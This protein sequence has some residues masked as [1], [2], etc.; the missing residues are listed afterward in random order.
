MATY[1]GAL[2]QDTGFIAEAP[3][4]IRSNF[5]A[6]KDNM[7]VDAGKL[8]GRVAGNAS[9]DIPI[10]NG[11]VCTNLNADMIDGYHA[12]SFAPIGHVNSATG[13][14]NAT[15]TA[16]GFMS[17]AQYL[18][19]E[20]I[21]AG[22]QVNQN[23]FSNIVVGTTT[24][25]ADSETDTLN[26]VG[27][28][29][30]T[31]TPDEIADKVIFSIATGAITT[32]HIADGTILTSD[33]ADGQITTAKLAASAVTTAKIAAGNITTALI[34]DGNV[35]TAKI[36]DS[37]VTTAKLADGSV[38][39]AKLAS[40]AAAANLGYTPLNAAGGTISGNLTV[41]GVTTLSST[42]GVSGTLTASGAVSVGTTL[43]VTG[44]TTLK[45]TLGV[46][47]ATTLS[48]TLDVSGA[49]TF[50]GTISAGTV[51]MRDSGVI[52]GL[53]TSVG[54]YFN[55][56]VSGMYDWARSKDVW[57]YTHN[58]STL[59]FMQ[60]AS[61]NST[62]SV[63]GALTAS[64]GITGSLTGNASTAT[65]L[66][67][68]RTISL[69]GDVTGS[70]SFDGSANANIIT[71][72]ANSGVTAGTYR[73]VTVDSKGRVIGGSNPTTL[74]GYGITDA[75]SLNS[76]MQTAKFIRYLGEPVFTSVQTMTLANILTTLMQNAHWHCADCSDNG[77]NTDN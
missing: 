1:N 47:G 4:Q 53:N 65:K 7:I 46:T 28:S 37:S 40:G 56:T 35:T 51:T 27:G 67:T 8:G 33:I 31:I 75:M 72:L 24:I 36:A 9:G 14:P 44:A 11:T 69:T 3:E 13:H 73:M 39:S 21:A 10:S 34:A 50:S 18:K 12:S 64:G 22:A 43:T 63:K 76:T 55:S 5:E 71:T 17:P 70:V 57:Y 66:A 2:P 38:T 30:I 6:L 59:T 26:L 54:Y 41:S 77:D 48:S 74:A 42:L 19:L 61:F 60:A 45:S 62:L 20:S 15:S 49:A 68:A 32:E 23:A 58:S 52:K 16:S 29:G 25:A